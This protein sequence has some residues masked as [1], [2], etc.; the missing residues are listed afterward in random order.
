[1]PWNVSP[2]SCS[3]DNLRVQVS[4]SLPGTLP[5][6]RDKT[7]HRCAPC[8]AE[9]STTR[10]YMEQRS[11]S[12]VALAYTASLGGGR[13]KKRGK[14][15]EN[16]GAGKTHYSCTCVERQGGMHLSKLRKL[17]RSKVRLES[18]S[19]LFETVD[20]QMISGAQIVLVVVLVNS[21]IG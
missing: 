20:R 21:A 13:E 10:L 5:M 14:S 19:H 3:N 6:D 11:L 9:R 16:P 4:V 1:L 7:M 18:G 15:C 17:E 8:T 2:C 12:S